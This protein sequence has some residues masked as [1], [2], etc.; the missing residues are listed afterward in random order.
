MTLRKKGINIANLT[1]INTKNPE[2]EVKSSEL[3]SGDSFTVNFGNN[4]SLRD[5]TG[6]GDILP[7]S[8]RKI[9]INGIEC[10]RS[11]KPRPGYYDIK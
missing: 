4:P 7:A 3:K 10:E 11:N 5:Q 6:A 8:V 1:L 9:I 2:V